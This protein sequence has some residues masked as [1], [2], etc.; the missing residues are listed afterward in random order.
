MKKKY[1]NN[2]INIIIKGDA[3]ALAKSSRIKTSDFL[4]VASYYENEEDYLVLS[5]LAGSLTAVATAFSS[6]PFYPQ[7]QSFFSK[8]FSKIGN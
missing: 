1:N 4:K 6:E 2:K 3:L 7:L 8:I 5:D